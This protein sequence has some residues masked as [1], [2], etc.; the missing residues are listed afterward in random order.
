MAST[1]ININSF[2]NHLLKMSHAHAG[3]MAHCSGFDK[4]KKKTVG[5]S[6]LTIHHG[7]YR[8]AKPTCVKSVQQIHY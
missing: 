4:K 8:F 1:R 7:R 6:I 3:K 2:K 5:K